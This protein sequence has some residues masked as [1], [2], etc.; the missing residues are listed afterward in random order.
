ME[1]TIRNRKNRTSLPNFE[2]D[3]LVDGL[4]RFRGL[5]KSSV[6]GSL[7]QF[8]VRY[9]SE[10]NKHR[11]TLSAKTSRVQCSTNRRRSGGDIFRTAKYYFP[12]CTLEQV[13]TIL[14]DI[15]GEDNICSSICYG[16]YKRVYRHDTWSAFVADRQVKD[17]FGRKPGNYINND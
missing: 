2:K 10:Y 11:T 13:L 16:I 1:F 14:D 12:N 15:S 8:I 3:L 9:L 6:T 17:E 4:L 5:N 7:K